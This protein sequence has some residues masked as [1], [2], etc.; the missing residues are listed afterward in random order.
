MS[1]INDALKKTQVHLKKTESKEDK[2][3]EPKQEN[4]TTPTNIYEKLY[5]KSREKQNTQNQ[6]GPKKDTSTPDA[7]LRAAKK[8]FKTVIAIIVLLAGLS[9]GFLFISRSPGTRKFLNSLKK[10]RPSSKGAIAKHPPKARKYKAGELVLNGTSLIDGKRVA[11]IND[12][13]YEIGEVIDGNKITSIDLNK[14]ELLGDEKI[15]TLKVH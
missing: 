12:E 5:K 2:K 6:T 8:W 9:G 14:V 10:D 4:P 11:L 1:I 13:I 7:P 3:P 15:I